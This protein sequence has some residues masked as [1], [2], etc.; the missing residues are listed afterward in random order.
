M[1][2]FSEK[3]ASHLVDLAS[4]SRKLK[5]E[6]MTFEETLKIFQVVLIIWGPK[7]MVREQHVKTTSP[8]SG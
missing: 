8:N 3:S 7:K 2:D 5:V 4:I 1:Q 6:I